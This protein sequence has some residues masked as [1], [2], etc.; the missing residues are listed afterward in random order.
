MIENAAFL[1]FLDVHTHISIYSYKC[2]KNVIEISIK[3]CELIYCKDCAEI[4]QLKN[5]IEFHSSTRGKLFLP[6]VF[7]F[8]LKHFWSAL[9]SPHL[10]L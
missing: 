4:L 2:R 6:E 10:L 5:I 7:P 9:R 3:S 1:I 8:F